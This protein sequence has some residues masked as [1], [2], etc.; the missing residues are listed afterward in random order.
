M[1]ELPGSGIGVPGRGVEYL[2]EGLEY[3]RELEYLGERGWSTWKRGFEYMGEGGWSTCVVPV[4]LRS[5]GP[6]FPIPYRRFRVH[7]L[8][9]DLGSKFFSRTEYLGGFSLK[10]RLEEHRYQILLARS[11]TEKHKLFRIRTEY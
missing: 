2:G 5:C 6:D 1:V 3:P 4:I 10:Y 7:Y 9:G 8:I 11:A